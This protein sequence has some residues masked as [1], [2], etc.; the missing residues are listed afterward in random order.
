MC[1]WLVGY[2]NSVG[3][4]V[5]WIMLVLQCDCDFALVFRVMLQ[6]L[7]Y[8]VCWFRLLIDLF[9][10]WLVM[11]GVVWCV[12]ACMFVGWFGLGF[13]WLRLGLICA[14]VFWLGWCYG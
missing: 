13:C 11:C 10:G 14:E 4:L 9:G 2:V 7:L 3:I 6:V 12:S 8:F 5:D 1:W